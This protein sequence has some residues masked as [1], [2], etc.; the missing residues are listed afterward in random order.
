VKLTSPPESAPAEYRYHFWIN[1]ALLYYNLR[2][3]EEAIQA[4]DRA[5]AIFDGDSTWYAQYAEVLAFQGKFDGAEK[6]FRT[7]IALR[8]APTNLDALAD[9][10]NN[11]GRYDEALDV[12]AQA[13]ARSGSDAWDVWLAY[14]ET[15]LSAG[16][17]QA[18]LDAIERVV[19]DNPFHGSAEAI[20]RGLAVRCLTVKGAAL[21][22]LLRPTEAIA[23][24]HEA[25]HVATSDPQV[26]GPLLVSVADAYWQTGRRAEARQAF[27]EARALGMEKGRTAK[28][29]ARL[30]RQISAFQ[31]K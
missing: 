31:G 2:R 17:P 30:E 1:A 24:L 4:F 23:V 10:L 21:L 3:A 5:R 18:A 11:R 22:A 29:M 25:M 14:S 28:T 16:R 15:A 12:Y 13:A 27:D 9:L 26:Q 6:N 20:G 8:P 19:A 7:S